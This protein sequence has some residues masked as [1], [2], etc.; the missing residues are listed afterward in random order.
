MAR[1][2]MMLKSRNLTINNKSD[3]NI[4]I[5]TFYIW[6]F[7]IIA[8]PQDF[9]ELMVHMRPALSVGIIVFILYLFYRSFYKHRFLDNQQCRLYLYLLL[10]MVISIPFAYYRRG[11][12]EFFFTKYITIVLFFFMFYKLIDN[13]KKINN[14][15]W[16]SCM[17]AS[18]YS[19]IAIY[20]GQQGS[21]RL[22]FGQMFDPND[23]AFFAVSILPFNILFIS[24]SDPWWKRL[25]CLFN[26]AI[27]ILF[28]MLT[29]SR[30]GLIALGIVVL[31]LLFTRSRSVNTTYKIII[32]T[33]MFVTVIYAGSAID[34]SRFETMTQIGEDYNVWDETGRL[35]I[36][37]KGF[38]LMLSDP[39]TGVGVSCFG[40]A[41]GRERLERGLPEIWQA[42]HNTIVQIGTETGI[43]G[44]ILF[45]FIS[46]KTFRI[47]GKAKDVIGAEDIAKI[48]SMARIGF[49]GHFASAMFLSQAYSVYWAF[50]TVLSASIGE[51]LR[52]EMTRVRHNS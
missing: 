41:I 50:Y 3:S 45:V 52:L 7:V 12:F 19:L 1:Y 13:T 5:Y 23:L 40:E 44:M 43:I 38:E 26:I 30:G 27:G 31:M 51:L 18:L 17:G 28:I 39:L 46:Y 10:T 22:E 21:G 35:Q 6:T 49:V 16:I 47:F 14:L 24:K 29:G 9:I 4:L 42:P 15:L 48:G 36:W 33:L 20:Q 25:I 34:Y 8:R 2:S 11:A 32:A 37:K